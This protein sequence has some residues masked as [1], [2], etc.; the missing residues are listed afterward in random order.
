MEVGAREILDTAVATGFTVSVALWLPLSVAVIEAVACEVT[1]WLVTVKVAVV[2]PP[3]TVTGV[4]TVAAA[5]LL[6]DSATATPPVGA[7]AFS[8]NVPVELNNPPATV[9]G[10]R[11]TD[12]TVNGLTVICAV[13][14]PL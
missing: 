11:T 5:V 7:G 14:V 12:A 9:A 2:A 6:L 1:V 13:A 10:L 4:V 3:A 8:V